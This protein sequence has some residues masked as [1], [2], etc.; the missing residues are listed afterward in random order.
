MNTSFKVSNLQAG[1]ARMEL[2][3]QWA[4]R[5][6]DEKFLSLG[7]LSSYLSDRDRQRREH[8]ASVDDFEVIHDAREV[9]LESKNGRRMLSNWSFGQLA[10]RAGAPASYLRSLS[11]KLASECIREGLVSA[12]NEQNK[13]YYS[14]DRVH[15]ITSPTYG[16]ISDSSVAAAVCK[17]AGNGTGD[18]RWKI[19]GT[20]DWRTMIY[21]PMTPI[22]KETTTLY[23]GDRD[24]WMFLVDDL[25]PIQ[26]GVARNG[27]PDYL[28]R[29][30]YVSNSEVG[31]G[32]L[33][34][35]T[36]YLRGLCCNRIMWGVEQFREI[37]IKHTRFAPD[38]FVRQVIPAL[39]QFAGGGEGKVIEGVRAA[40]QAV[41]GSSD[42]ESIEFLRKFG[43][44]ARRAGEVLS[45]HVAEEGQPVRTI[46]DAANGIT[47]V[48]RSCEWQDE[49]VT[50]ELTAKK[51]LDR[52]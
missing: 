32:V 27:E 30:F 4:T 42:E 7:D 21:D 6:D 43:L 20:M 3:K 26:V 29:G 1:E 39:A 38:R 15:A 34:L 36:F 23:A 17:L 40:K 51:L 18:T 25:N 11:P 12:T 37:R 13:F 49:R 45:V 19:P 31:A 28:F 16:R 22:T 5:P 33:Q 50:L 44:T 48:A 24:V 41:I 9:M 8:V 46:W 52:V 10:Q 2:S 35:A 14:K 47:A